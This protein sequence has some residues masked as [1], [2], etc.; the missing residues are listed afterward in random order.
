V[1]NIGL[2][3]IWRTSVVFFG[4]HNHP[5]LARQ[6]AS[7]MKY[8]PVKLL[9]VTAIGLLAATQPGHF[10]QS[11]SFHPQPAHARQDNLPVENL[12]PTENT[13]VTL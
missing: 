8:Y 9:A 2:A 11:K 5:A 6:F 4:S 7:R 10:L 3:S 13:K 12:R 1:W